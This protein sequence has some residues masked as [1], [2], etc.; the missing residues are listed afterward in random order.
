MS[1]SLA[2]QSIVALQSGDLTKIGL[3]ATA[4]LIVG[5]LLLSL[6]ITAV[7]GRIL[8]LVV[9]VGLSVLVWQQRENIQHH[10]KDCQLRMTFVGVH[11]DAPA[12]V[13]AKCRAV[14][15]VAA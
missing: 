9:V 4:A 11:V 15:R 3:I 7:V 6:V 13:I 12:D 14:H 8:I 5:G 1:A 10:I 2:S